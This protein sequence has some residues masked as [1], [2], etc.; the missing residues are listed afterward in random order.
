MS[1]KP[2]RGTQLSVIINNDRKELR[3]DGKF[4]ELT[5]S[6]TQFYKQSPALLS[7][8]GELA[9]TLIV[10]QAL[11]TAS[12][13]AKRQWSSNPFLLQR[14]QAIRNSVRG[15][16]NHVI[17]VRKLSDKISVKSL[18]ELIMQGAMIVFIYNQRGVNIVL[19]ICVRNKKLSLRT[20]MA[21]LIQVKGRQELPVDISANFC[22]TPWNHISDG[23]NYNSSTFATMC[24]VRWRVSGDTR[25]KASTG[26]SRW[27]QALLQCDTQ[28]PETY[29]L[30]EIK[31]NLIS[32]DVK[33]A[34]G[35]AFYKLKG[36]AI[37]T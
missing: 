24:G 34:K 13:A 19:P 4:Y 15:W 3:E 18:W 30:E 31:D 1:A 17:K 36:A 22:L 2:S 21:I 32:D 10:M 6:T 11:D 5:Q 23:T 14:G 35:A 9:A 33:K 25:S 37:S 16:F 12:S 7:Q 29:V 8:R 20:T 27:Y 26:D 28:S